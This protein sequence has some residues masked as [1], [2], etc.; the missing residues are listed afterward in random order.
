M[1]M[2]PPNVDASGNAPIVEGRYLEEVYSDGNVRRRLLRSRS[3]MLIA[4]CSPD[5][6]HEPRGSEHLRDVI[7]VQTRAGSNAVTL[8]STVFFSAVTSSH[9]AAGIHSISSSDTHKMVSTA[10]RAYVD[11]VIVPNPR[12]FTDKATAS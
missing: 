10:V 11:G 6:P 9:V 2:F 7:Y 3:C 12:N 8:L 5:T 1:A 4:S